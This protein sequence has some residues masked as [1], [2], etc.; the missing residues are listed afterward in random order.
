MAKLIDGA[1]DDAVSGIIAATGPILVTVTG[2]MKTGI[3]RITGDIG[4][5]EA[6]AYKYFA[7]DPTSFARLEFA[8]GVNFKAYL[9]GTDGHADTDV[10]VD[11]IAV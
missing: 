10:T 8:T 5:G 11:Y 9:E 6:D 4:G 7:G 1:T 2:V 3:V